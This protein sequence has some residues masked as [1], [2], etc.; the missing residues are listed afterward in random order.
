MLFRTDERAFN[1]TNEHE[2]SVISAVLK[3]YCREL[4]EPIFN[5]PLAD[6][7]RYTENRGGFCPE[8]SSMTGANIDSTR[9]IAYKQQLLR[10]PRE[11]IEDAA[12]SPIHLEDHCG[13]FVPGCSS[14]RPEQDGRQSQSR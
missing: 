8:T 4:P 10:D 14:F 2:V 6:R 3:K 11:T 13:A 9:R 12:Y 5:F 1:F 7:I